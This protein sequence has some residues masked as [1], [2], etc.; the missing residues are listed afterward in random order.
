MEPQVLPSGNRIR[1]ATA[2]DAADII[3]LIKALA[4]YEKEG[5]KVDFFIIVHS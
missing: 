3:R 2:A 4:T 5:D 1:P